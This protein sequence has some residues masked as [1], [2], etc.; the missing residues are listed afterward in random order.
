MRTSSVFDPVYFRLIFLFKRSYDEHE[1]G[2]ER[3]LIHSE[4]L[5]RLLL[6]RC[7]VSVLRDGATGGVM[8]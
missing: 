4:P 5:Y 1:A 7:H 2:H 8:I 3:E 6:F